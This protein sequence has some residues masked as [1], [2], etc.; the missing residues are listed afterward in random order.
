VRMWPR[1]VDWRVFEKRHQLDAKLEEWSSELKTQPCEVGS[2]ILGAVDAFQL[3]E[4][5]LPDDVRRALG[6]LI[7]AISPVQLAGWSRSH[8][9]PYAATEYAVYSPSTVQDVLSSFDSVE[10]SRLREEV[11]KVWGHLN[12]QDNEWMFVDAGF[13]QH[14]ESCRD[15]IDYLIGWR[16]AFVE[17]VEAGKGLLIDAG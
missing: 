2:A 8:T 11:S 17:A 12:E 13:W 6:T 7:L 4:R 3:I 9:A 14:S 16:A 10:Q 15:F 5:F 1:L